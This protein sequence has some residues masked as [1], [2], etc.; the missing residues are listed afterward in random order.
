[1]THPVGRDAV[2]GPPSIPPLAGREALP[3]DDLD[4]ELSRSRALPF[5]ARCWEGSLAWGVEKL[6]KGYAAGV[7]TL[8]KK[9]F[10]ATGFLIYFRI[11][12]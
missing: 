11:I 10:V 6:N 8:W 3:D 2:H 4:R 5:H 12:L 9:S 7:L 1:M